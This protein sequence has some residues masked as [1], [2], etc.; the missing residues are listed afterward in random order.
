MGIPKGWKTYQKEAYHGKPFRVYV[1]LNGWFR[2]ACHPKMRYTYPSDA[3]GAFR[4]YV[5]TEEKK[6]E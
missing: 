2:I 3:I 6:E 5:L 4:R 1:D